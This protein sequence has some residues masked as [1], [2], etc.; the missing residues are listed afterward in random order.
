MENKRVVVS[1]IIPAYNV[2]STIVDAIR[3]VLLQTHKEFEILVVN[4]GST[5]LTEA[6]V[7]EL[8]LENPSIPIHYHQQKNQGASQARNTGVDFANGEYIVFLD[9][10]DIL[11][12]TYLEKCLE[13]YARNEELDVVYSY[14]K[15]F[16]REQGEVIYAQYTSKLILYANMIPIYAMIKKVN[17][18]KIGGFDVKLKNHEDWEFWLRYTY[19][20]GGNVHQIPEFLYAYRKRNEQNSITDLSIQTREVEESYVYIFYKNYHIYKA[21]GY[22]IFSILEGGESEYAFYKRKYYNV[23]YRKLIYRLFKPI[24]YRKIYSK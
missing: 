18:L 23:W 17:F 7:Q 14:T 12:P 5:D 4:D 13:C 21:K 22:S 10:D 3:S 24:K 15:L 16:E 1:V 6:L 9:A 8:I 2:E 11:S 20:I 19:F